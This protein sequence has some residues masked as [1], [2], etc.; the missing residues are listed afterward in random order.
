MYTKTSNGYF[1]RHG[2]SKREMPI[3]QLAGLLQSR[4]QARIIKFDE[5]LVPNTHRETLRESLYRRFITEGAAE[6]DI[7]DLLL[8]RS[9][10]IQ[11]G[12][13]IHASVAGILMCH[14]TPMITS[15]TVL[16]KQFIIMAK[17]KMP[18]IKLMQKILEDRLT[19]RL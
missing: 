9:L 8:K 4:S 19:N 10:L 13:E 5:Q 16:F 18:T 12:R 1:T 14:N 15:I 17:K 2:S 7:E 6:D 11:E 3:D